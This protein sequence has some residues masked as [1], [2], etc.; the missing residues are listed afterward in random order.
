MA[1]APDFTFSSK[2]QTTNLYQW[3]KTVTLI[4]VEGLEMLRR[5][6]Q[7]VTHGIVE[8]AGLGLI[9]TEAARQRNRIVATASEGDNFGRGTQV[10]RHR[11]SVEDAEVGVSLEEQVCECL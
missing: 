5:R 4:C 11:F 10:Q 9:D 2:T 1:F 6:T 3:E 8:L 7:R